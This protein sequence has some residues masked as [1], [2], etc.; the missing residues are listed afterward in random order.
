MI[1]DKGDMLQ[2]LKHFDIYTKVE[3]DFRV[4][5]SGGAT[6]SI[7]GWIIIFILTF[8]ELGNYFR[9]ETVEHMS[10][11]TSLGQQLQINI[12]IT[13]HA[14]TCAEV[15]LD[16]M[17]V[18]GDNQLNI[19]HDMYKQRVSP[20]GYLIGDPATEI[21]GE[22]EK[23]P[24]LPPDY[25]GS[26]YGAETM[27]KKCCNTCAELKKA[28]DIKGWSI[29]DILKNA[30]QCLHDKSNPFAAV[31]KGEGCRVTGVMKV[32]KVSGNFHM[33]LG[34]SIV[35]DGRHIHQFIPSEAPGFNVSHT[36]HSI[37]FGRPFPTMPDNPLDSVVRIVDE[38]VGTGLFQYFIHVIPTTFIG[39]DG[40]THKILTN[41]YTFT[42]RFRPLALP[43]VAGSAPIMQAAV[44]PGIFF[45]YE[46]SPFVVEVKRVQMPFLHLLT[47]LLAIVGGA[48]SIL[49]VI[50]A[51]I[52]RI[53]KMTTKKL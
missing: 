24:E 52:F 11:D 27:D 12:N 13:F 9:V 42:E 1:R 2:T 8:A 25:C 15:H 6:L 4:R 38:K 53:Q 40:D 28:Y 39:G 31:R 43:T 18:A 22:V 29:T 30:T 51:V 34:D 20:G 41:Q 17:D 3:E 46:L 14:L 5:T 48:F 33:A 23:V 21:I 32:N 16:A 37:S 45:V 10:V 26:C 44:L 36:I 47:K 50:D 19:E 7:F 35:R 49:G